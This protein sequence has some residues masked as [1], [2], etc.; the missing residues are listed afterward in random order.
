MNQYIHATLVVFI[1]ILCCALLAATI[2]PTPNKPF[3]P[4]E[5][6]FILLNFGTT[7]HPQNARL[8]NQ[9]CLHIQRLFHLRQLFVV[10]VLVT[11]QKTTTDPKYV[12]YTSVLA[13]ND[14]TPTYIKDVAASTS[15]TLR[16][17]DLALF[18]SAN[19]TYEISGGES[20]IVS[21]RLTEN[22]QRVAASQKKFP[23]KWKTL[24]ATK[25]NTFKPLAVQQE[26]DHSRK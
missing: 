19:T 17:G 4:R 21:W 2:I 15:V 24:K 8:L 9:I 3:S 26:H 25:K 20:Y 12:L 10:N 16:K 11:T 18:Y 6:R 14:D 22:R 7:Q 23:M 13:L 5:N 1:S